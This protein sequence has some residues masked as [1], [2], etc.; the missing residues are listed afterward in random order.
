MTRTSV[1]FYIPGDPQCEFDFVATG[2][3]EVAAVT[4]RSNAVVKS[5]S[6]TLCKYK[7]IEVVQETG[8]KLL[9]VKL[10]CKVCLKI[11]NM[12]FFFL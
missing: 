12:P 3:R 2:N 5:N 11:R 6:E 4:Q 8:R 7:K 1:S 9:Q 10:H